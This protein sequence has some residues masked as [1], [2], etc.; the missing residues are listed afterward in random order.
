M[1]VY[2]IIMFGRWC[3]QERKWM[4]NCKGKWAM[5]RCMHASAIE[6]VISARWW[7]V[8]TFLILHIIIIIIII[9]PSWAPLHVA[10]TK[11]WGQTSGFSF[12]LSSGPSSGNFRGSHCQWFHHVSPPVQWLR[13]KFWTCCKF[14]CS[15]RPTKGVPCVMVN[16]LWSLYG[17]KQC[18][19]WLNCLA[20]SGFHISFERNVQVDNV[21]VVIPT[22]QP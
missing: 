11:L 13:W 14:I 2:H 1:G 5:E 20:L 18:K 4:K 19:F 22:F 6:V 10:S 9:S 21:K 3:E 16:W 17:A 12:S 15:F 7:M 8:H